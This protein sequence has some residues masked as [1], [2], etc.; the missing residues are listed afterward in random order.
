LFIFLTF[1][2]CQGQNTFQKVYGNTS[3][4]HSEDMQETFDSSFIISGTFNLGTSGVLL[5]TNKYGTPIWSK[6]YTVDT[7]IL[8]PYSVIQTKDSGFVVTGAIGNYGQKT[9]VFL[10]KVDQNGNYSWNKVYQAVQDTL[11]SISYSVVQTSDS[12]FIICG[13]IFHDVFALRYNLR[14]FIIKTDDAGNLQWTKTYNGALNPLS[15]SD[16]Q[17]TSDNGY[18]IKGG[19]YDFFPNSGIL[20]LKLNNTGIPVWSRKIVPSSSDSIL[21]IGD[22]HNYIITTQNTGYA[23]SGLFQKGLSSILYPYLIKTDTNGVLMWNKTYSAIIS[24][25]YGGPSIKNTKDNG[26]ILSGEIEDSL[27]NDNIYLMKTDNSGNIK[28][29]RTWGNMTDGDKVGYFATQTIDNG[30]AVLGQNLDYPKGNTYL[31]KTDSTGNSQCG[32]INFPIIVDT[33]IFLD[34]LVT[35]QVDS[36]I[37]IDTAFIFITSVALIDTVDVC[38]PAI[39]QS[40]NSQKN[41]EF[42]IFPNPNDGNMSLKYSI[43]PNERS[44]IKIYDVTG[45]LVGETILNSN[46]NQLQIATDLDKGIY[47]YQIIV[48]DRI[49][50]IDKMIIIR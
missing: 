43:K 19:V 11:S 49:V 41:E 22:E 21:L 39:V 45:K 35:L 31:I 34:S 7:T 48:D 38:N 3:V 20:L 50:K 40:V 16:I 6:Q 10:L 1:A 15:F 14:G 28:W 8:R 47:L 4:F 2:L 18:V 9:N 33:K 37:F 46:I 44:L 13:I 5:K 25:E 12:G 42:N 23:L 36:N 30:F 24:D 27:D 26:F 32:Q 17:Q 29:N